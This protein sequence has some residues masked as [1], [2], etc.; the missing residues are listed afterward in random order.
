MKNQRFWFGILLM[1]LIFGMTVV[2][3]D[4]DTT[5]NGNNDSNGNGDGYDNSDLYGVW[6]SVNPIFDDI[7]MKFT[8]SGGIFTESIANSKTAL[9]WKVVVIG[10]YPKDAKSPVTVTMTDANT[11]LWGGADEWKIWENLG[12]TY[13][14]A[15]GGSQTYPI[16][17]S[18][19]QFTAG[20]VI[21][22][23]QSI[24]NDISDLNGTW[25]SVD[26][27]FDDIFM[28]FVASEGIFTESIANSETALLWKVVVIGSYPKDEKSPVTVT[29]TD[30]NTSMWGGADEWETWENLGTTYQETAGGSQTYPITIS[31]N[32]FT[33]G[34]V[35]FKKQ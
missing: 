8:A 6:I 22:E 16:T 26:P 28:K 5:G 14:E 19:N 10:S 20:G 13:K 30:A 4:N 29:T 18:N 2:G 34:G 32:Q 33:A 12:I 3:C 24:G 7:Y 17:I 15:A 21:F 23:R 31:N 11:S 1:V 35:I 9:S 25:I 27:I